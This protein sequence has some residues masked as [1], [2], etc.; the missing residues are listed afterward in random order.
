MVRTIRTLLG[1]S[2]HV[3]GAAG[4]PRRPDSV[5]A[6]ATWADLAANR[7]GS[8]AEERARQARRASPLKS[9]LGRVF[10]MS[11]DEKEWRVGA[12]GQRKVGS[13]LSRLG[14]S[15]RVLHAIPVG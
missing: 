1:M 8:G 10:R 12:A 3:A 11:T 7:P 4:H 9:A 15:W 13:T 6:S 14:Q 2:A 5:L